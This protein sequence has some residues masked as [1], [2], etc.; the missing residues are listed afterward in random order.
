MVRA[1]FGWIGL[2]VLTVSA[3]FGQLQDNRE[4]ELSCQDGN[5]DRRA[6]KCEIRE[7]TL[8]SVGQLT[9][10]PNRNGGVSVKGWTRSDVLVRARLEAW[11]GSDSEASLTFSQ[12]HSDAAAGRITAS[13]PEAAEWAVS[14]EVFVPQT[15]DLK[16]MT[17]NGGLH[18][19]DINGRMDLNTT[20]GGL[21]LNRVIGDITAKTTNGGVHVTLASGNWQGRQLD[22]ETTNGGV[23]VEAPANLQARIQAETTN[24]GIRSDFGGQ[25]TG[26]NRPRTLDV[27]VGGGGATLKLV[28]KN[29]A[30]HVS[31]ARERIV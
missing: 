28:T 30:I 11:G 29:G 16:I 5:R 27:T 18:I 3:A 10:D 23:H 31:R 2:T 12:L 7:Q 19:S 14:Y 26:R 4:K 22:L 1:T 9:L 17:H 13:G 25:T 8:A 24:G 21:H 6:H 15:H 20:N